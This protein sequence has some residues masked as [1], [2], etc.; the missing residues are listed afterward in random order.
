[1]VSSNTQAGRTRS[2]NRDPVAG[3]SAGPTGSRFRNHCGVYRG[4]A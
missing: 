4:S 1:M 3:L 2:C